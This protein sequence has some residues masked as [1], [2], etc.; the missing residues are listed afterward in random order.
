MLG[1]MNMLG[2]YELKLHRRIIE[3]LEDYGLDRIYLCG[4]LM[5]QAY[6]QTG[7]R[8]NVR[9]LTD[10]VSLTRQLNEDLSGGGH[11]DA[12]SLQLHGPGRGAHPAGDPM[13]PES[14]TPEELDGRIRR[15]FSPTAA[16]G[17]YAIGLRTG[18]VLSSWQED[19]PRMMA[20][21][22]KLFTIGAAL[23]ILP[24]RCGERTELLQRC[25]AAGQKSDNTVADE[26]AGQISRQ[27]RRLIRL[28]R[29]A[30]HTVPSSSPT[31]SATCCAG[32]PKAG[33]PRTCAPNTGRSTAP[34]TD[35]PTGPVPGW[36][37]NTWLR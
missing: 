24:V 23:K 2:Q 36:W 19:Q 5:G 3:T 22:A 32:A 33:Q 35:S 9:H 10:T 15:L 29:P 17:A 12:Q 4:E 13:A 28:R 31:T 18:A 8:E 6:E 26:I 16:A 34:G 21:T 7:P 37:P 11:G 14:V 1:D 20:S 27:R 30:P 25:A